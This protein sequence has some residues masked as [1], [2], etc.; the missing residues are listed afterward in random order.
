MA[1]FEVPKTGIRI[2]TQWTQSIGSIRMSPSGAAWCCRLTA[3]KAMMMPRRAALNSRSPAAGR[4]IS[5]PR[6]APYH[7]HRI[8]RIGSTLKLRGASP[9]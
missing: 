1:L 9:R 7:P 4:Q 8:T 5:P 3:I 6:F 2:S